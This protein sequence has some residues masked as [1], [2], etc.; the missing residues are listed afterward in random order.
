MYS[1]QVK[2]QISKIVGGALVAVTLAT[3]CIVPPATQEIS[4]S[5]QT[6]AAAPA[7]PAAI[8]DLYTDPAG[9]FSAPIPTNWTAIDKAG[10]GLLSDPEG[11]IKVYLLALAEPDPEVAL[12]AAWQ[13]ADPSLTLNVA[14]GLEQPATGGVDQ[15]YLAQYENGPAGEFYQATARMVDGTAYLM[16]IDAQLAALQRRSAQVNII[17][18]GL[19]ISGLRTVDL[20]EVDPLPVDDA[21]RTELRSFIEQGLEKY[22]IPGTAVSVVQNGQVVYQETFGTTVLGGDVPLTPQTQLMIGSTGKSLTTLL[23]A[24]LVDAGLMS[25]DTPVV[26]MLP[27]FK[28]ADEQLT[29]RITLRN[30]VC[31]CTGVP[32]RDLELVFNAN[33]LTAED[34]VESLHS[35]EFFTD[36]GETF[37]YS[38]QMVAT[39][40]FASAAADGATFGQLENGYAAALARR[41]LN[42]VGMPNTTISFDEVLARGDYALPHEMSFGVRYRPIAVADEKV[43]APISPAGTHWSTLDDMTNYL[44]MALNKGV[45][46]DGTRVVSEENLRTTWAPQVPISAQMSYGLGWFVDEYKGAPLIQHGGNTLGFTSD[47][48]FLPEHGLGIVVLTNVRA[49][50][51]FNQGVRNRLFELVFAQAAEAAATADFQF[52][53]LQERLVEPPL[54]APGLAESALAPYLG[55]FHNAAL[56][57]L[58]LTLTDGVLTAD[59]GEFTVTLLPTEHEGAVRY[60]M[61]DGLLAGDAL[62]LAQDEAGAAT[63]SFGEGVQQY[64][65]TQ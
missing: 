22:G 17:D 16:L 61:V 5:A 25:W 53:Q 37:Q 20:A 40:G 34:I 46:A 64:T 1:R 50:N 33:E 3:G 26:G 11:A 28:V 43:L 30:L 14:K 56:G 15:L 12:A 45:A 32:R 21:I 39:G 52:T 57:D 27:Q 19:T 36:F 18:S 23:M 44:I 55:T 31:A 24:T 4:S 42:P 65:F 29:Q 35:F 47:F 13:L 54:F 48:A 7:Q 10:Y 63:V 41:V 9:R 60:V 58:T 6:A 2:A 49:S 62:T 38:N 8:S 59:A 51:Y